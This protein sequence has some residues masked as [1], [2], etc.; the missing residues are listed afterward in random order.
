MAVPAWSSQFFVFAV[1]ELEGVSNSIPAEKRPLIDRRVREILRPEIQQ[2][3]V[4]SFA[5]QIA[6]AYP[7][8]TVHAKQVRNTRSTKAFQYVDQDSHPWGLP[9]DS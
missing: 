1:K 3:L 7:S 8:S 9:L 4:S 5:Q 6:T 2:Q